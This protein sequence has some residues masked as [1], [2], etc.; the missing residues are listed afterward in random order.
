MRSPDQ[1]LHRREHSSVDDVRAHQVRASVGSMRWRFEDR[2]DAGCFFNA[3]KTPAI[4]SKSK[5]R[6]RDL[7]WSGLAPELSDQVE[8]LDRSGCANRMAFRQ[9]SS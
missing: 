1:R 9:Q 7:P 4:L 6:T 3:M 2:A 5:A 8:Q